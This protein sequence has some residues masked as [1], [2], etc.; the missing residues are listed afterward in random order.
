MIWIALGTWNHSAGRMLIQDRI[1]LRGYKWTP[2][3]R[4]RWRYPDR[5]LASVVDCLVTFVDRHGLLGWL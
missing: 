1:R 4:V 2:F 3:V 5:K